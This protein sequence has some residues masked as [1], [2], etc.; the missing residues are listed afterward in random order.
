MSNNITF[1]NSYG[2]PIAYLDSDGVH[3]FGFDGTPLGY[4][5]NEKVYNF[6][7]RFLG[8]FENGWLYDLT[9]SPTFFTEEAKGGPLKPLKQLKPLK[10]LKQ[11]KPLKGLKELTPLKP[12][13]SLNWSEF[14][15]EM[16]FDQE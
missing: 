4:L 1:Y 11:L 6:E 12:L 10:G 7:G 14:S 15:D 9:N 13:R 2:A 3:I 8:W 16:Y 5:K